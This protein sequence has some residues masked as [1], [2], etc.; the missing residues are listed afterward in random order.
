MTA[1][2]PIAA[3]GSDE[4]AGGYFSI[5]QFFRSLSRILI[6]TSQPESAVIGG[7]L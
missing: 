6:G 3:F 1:D 5:R 4:L 7:C 2:L